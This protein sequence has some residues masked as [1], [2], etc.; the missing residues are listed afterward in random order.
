MSTVIW[1]QLPTAM[2]QTWYSDFYSDLI[3]VLLPTVIL[4]LQ[5]FDL[6]TLFLFMLSGD[7]EEFKQETLGRLLLLEPLLQW[8]LLAAS[9]W[10]FSH[11]SF[12]AWPWCAVSSS[13][14]E[15]FSPWWWMQNTHCVQD[16]WYIRYHHSNMYFV[17][18]LKC[19][20]CYNR[21]SLNPENICGYF[22][23]YTK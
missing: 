13:F 9:T 12:S 17:P 16:V 1:V 5:W 10:A 22:L 18:N 11:P 6:S 15:P 19:L 20:Y 7:L 14:L 4:L 21:P 2:I 23:V 3:W 8:V